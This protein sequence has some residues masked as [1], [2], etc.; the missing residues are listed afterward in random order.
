MGLFSAQTPGLQPLVGAAPAATTF[1]ANLSFRTEHR[2]A[3]LLCLLFTSCET[4][5]VG[6]FYKMVFGFNT[7]IRPPPTMREPGF[8]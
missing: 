1:T 4:E 7:R 6:T 2:E 8:W 5:L 3:P